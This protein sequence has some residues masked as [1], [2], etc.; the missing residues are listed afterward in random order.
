M[1]ADIERDPINL[2]MRLKYSCAFICV[3]LGL[4]LNTLYQ[5]V[6]IFIYV[7][8]AH[9]TVLY[10]HVV[11]AHK[12]RHRHIKAKHQK[13]RYFRAN[14]PLLSVFMWGVN[15]TVSGAFEVT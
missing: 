11:T 3:I 12:V 5:V 15:Q 10:M 8:F 14:D 13:K 4:L 6:D 9:F 7:T 2:K 1:L